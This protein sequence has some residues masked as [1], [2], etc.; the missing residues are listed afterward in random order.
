MDFAEVRAEVQAAGW[1]LGARLWGVKLQTESQNQ[2]GFRTSLRAESSLFQVGSSHGAG[3]V[4]LQQQERT[5]E[6]YCNN[7]TSGGSARQPGPG[8]EETAPPGSAAHPVCGAGAATGGRPKLLKEEA[9]VTPE[10]VSRA[11]APAILR[12]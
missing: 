6:F 3:I 7:F 10:Q 9:Q 1:V 4:V 5:Q 2:R 12:A 11:G 8:D